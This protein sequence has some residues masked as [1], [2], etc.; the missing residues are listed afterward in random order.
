MYL[1]HEPV[2]GSRKYAMYSVSSLWITWKKDKN[3]NSYRYSI[4]A[5]DRKLKS[6][7]WKIT[8][9]EA[10]EKTPLPS[11]ISPSWR[12]SYQLNI[13]LHISVYIFFHYFSVR[14]SLVQL[15]LQ[16]HIFRLFPFSV[17]T[18]YIHLSI[19][20]LRIDIHMWSE[21]QEHIYVG[22]LSK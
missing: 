17:R 21:Q 14:D 6:N 2:V 4:L 15:W 9:R 1:G 12:C 18:N 7:F 10:V 20:H 13:Y 11:F 22:K 19:K 16:F 5:S 3:L 8:V